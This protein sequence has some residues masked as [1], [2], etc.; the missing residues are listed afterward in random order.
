MG[1]VW[2]SKVNGLGFWRLDINRPTIVSLS[3][4]PIWSY[5]MKLQMVIWSRW[6]LT[7]GCG[8]CSWLHCIKIIVHD[9]LQQ[10]H[11]IWALYFHLYYHWI[12]P[13]STQELKLIRTMITGLLRV[14]TRLMG[15]KTAKNLKRTMVRGAICRV[16]ADGLKTRP[17][18]RH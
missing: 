2:D 16:P 10:F 15:K 12:A 18:T 7:A 4:D 6:L 8:L 1:Y 13:K 5:K 3:I 17:Y 11:G 14:W 9:T